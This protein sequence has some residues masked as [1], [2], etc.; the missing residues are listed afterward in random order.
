MGK[1]AEMPAPGK[2]GKSSFRLPQI[3]MTG[4]ADGVRLA[5]P[6]GAL[7]DKDWLSIRPSPT[8]TKSADFTRWSKSTQSSTKSIPDLISASAKATRPAAMP[9]PAPEPASLKLQEQSQC[10]IVTFL[11]QLF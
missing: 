2:S 5:T 3:A 4:I 10:R 8:I 1:A 7:P 6:T 11:G 9:P